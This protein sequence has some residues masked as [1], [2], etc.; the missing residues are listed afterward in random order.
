MSAPN[1]YLKGLCVWQNSGLL[2]PS[3]HVLLWSALF[4]VSWVFIVL[5]PKAVRSSLA[6]LL[7]ILHNPVFYHV[8]LDLSF[9]FLSLPLTVLHAAA[10]SDLYPSLLKA[11]LQ[12]HTK[13]EFLWRHQTIWPVY[14]AVF[15]LTGLSNQPPV[16]TWA[17]GVLI[18]FLCLSCP[19]VMS[20]PES[21]MASSLPKSSLLSKCF[22]VYTY[23][24]ESAHHSHSL[25]LS[26]PRVGKVIT[27]VDF[28]VWGNK[29]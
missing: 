24:L 16:I 19:P 11:S 9:V 14:L 15:S 3:Q 26:L 4:S 7:L 8:P 13:S 12:L 18:G 21:F 2:L 25:L 22:P 28:S 29:T 17:W 27:Q 5:S 20:S 10:E 1:R 6:P 23:F